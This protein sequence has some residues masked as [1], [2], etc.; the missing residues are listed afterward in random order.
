MSPHAV[1]MTSPT[2]TYATA[3][4]LQAIMKC[5]P[6]RYP[7]LLVD[8]IINIVPGESGIGIK[9]VTANEPYFTGHFP[10]HP[11]M[12]GVL[13]VEAMAQTAG[14]LVCDYLHQGKVHNDLVYFLSIEQARF[15]KPVVPGD[16]VQLQVK[17]DRQRG[18]VWRFSGKAM[19]DGHLCA[20]AIFTAMIVV[21]DQSPPTS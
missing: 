20:E 9:N 11:I 16:T 2:P 19:V 8:K 10:D 21:S 13:I 3:L 14:A 4:D 5:I 17:K 18:M 15:R 7:M 1:K 6:H 12:P